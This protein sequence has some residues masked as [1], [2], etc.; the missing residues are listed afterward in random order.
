MLATLSA[1]PVAGIAGA[2]LADASNADDAELLRLGAELD[3]LDAEW[4]ALS[5]EEPDSDLI[6]W[7]SFLD[8]FGELI[9]QIMPLRATSLA[10]IA[11]QARALVIGQSEWWQGDNSEFEMPRL[12]LESLCAFLNVVPAPLRFRHGVAGQA[13][14][15]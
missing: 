8:R 3:R 1:V 15:S 13:V 2:A 4:L 14:R 5:N 12:F 6:A 10:G 11:V 9:E 7:S